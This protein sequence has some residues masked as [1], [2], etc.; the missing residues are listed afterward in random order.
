MPASID[1]FDRNGNKIY[2]YPK[3]YYNMIQ[4]NHFDSY[5]AF[6]GF[7]NLSGDIEV[8]DLKTKYKIG[9]CVADASHVLQWAPDGVSFMTACVNPK[10][11]VD[12]NIQVWSVRGDRNQIVDFVETE[13][14]RVCWDKKNS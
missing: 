3:S 13:L 14:Y 8:W 11:R 5:I 1:T 12:N 6:A 2:S 7:G 10:L 4:Y 9:K